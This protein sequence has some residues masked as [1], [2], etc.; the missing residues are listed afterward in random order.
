MTEEKFLQKLQ[1]FLYLYFSFFIAAVTAEYISHI[2]SFW[3]QCA[4]ILASLMQV[5]KLQL[6]SDP[7]SNNH[8][9]QCLATPSL[10]FLWVYFQMCDCAVG[11]YLVSYESNLPK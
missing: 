9:W 2:D 11:V 8:L 6:W 1:S 4:A 10:F 3:Q 5:E 7:A